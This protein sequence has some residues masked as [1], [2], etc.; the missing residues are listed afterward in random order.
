MAR[1]KPELHAMAV[2][3]IPDQ[4]RMMAHIT[5]VHCLME[6]AVLRGRM[7]AGMPGAARALVIASMDF[8]A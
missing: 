6:T 3:S 1:P 2:R 7:M 5:L 8:V 4:R